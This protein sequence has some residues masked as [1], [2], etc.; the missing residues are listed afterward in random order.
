MHTRFGDVSLG[1]TIGV[2][3]IV[4]NIVECGSGRARA[5][6]AAATATDKVEVAIATLLS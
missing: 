5:E 3:N 2:D 6:N 1:R 4:D